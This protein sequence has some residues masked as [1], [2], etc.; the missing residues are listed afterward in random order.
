[1]ERGTWGRCPHG[2]A[3][4]AR[5]SRGVRGWVWRAARSLQHSPSPWGWEQAQILSPARRLARSRGRLA[6]GKLSALPGCSRRAKNTPGRR[7]GGQRRGRLRLQA[8]THHPRLPE[9][10]ETF[11]D[12]LEGSRCCDPSSSSRFAGEAA[13]HQ[14]FPRG[15]GAMPRTPA[16]SLLSPVHHIPLVTAPCP[17]SL[18]QQDPGAVPPQQMSQQRG[19]FFIIFFLLLLKSCLAAYGNNKSSIIF[20]GE[21]DG[22]DDWFDS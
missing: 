9:S 21:A 10:P 15:V 16:P 13:G 3:Q 20:N 8:V 22:L 1:M 18:C 14:P 2:T 19:F 17:A 12:V 4:A 5:G 11:G 7:S 6:D